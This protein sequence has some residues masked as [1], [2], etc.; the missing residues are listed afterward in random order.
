MTVSIALIRHG[1]TG[2]N[3]EQRL[4]G[5]SDQPLSDIGRAE[6]RRWHLPD[7]LAGFTLHVS[8]M[9]RARETADI[10]TGGRA[11]QIEPALIEMGFGDWEGQT[12]P[13]LRRDLGEEM[14]RNEARGLD[15][16][17]PNGESPRDVIARLTPL[18]ATWAAGQDHRLAVCHK[19]VI[20]AVHAWASDWNMIGKP[21]HK[22]RWDCAHLFDLT[23]DGTP[24]IARLNIPLVAAP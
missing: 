22:L 14:T 8:P 17:P 11:A 12:L 6:V 13:D 15:F 9:G 2:W 23:P 24:R 10:L 21:P 16:T 7:D 3:A 18:F 19:A 4:Q 20:R 5:H 1:P